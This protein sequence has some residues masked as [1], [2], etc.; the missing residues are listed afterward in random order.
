MQTLPGAHQ[1]YKLAPSTLCVLRASG[2]SHPLPSVEKQ[3][4]A[5]EKRGGGGLGLGGG[6]EELPPSHC[7]LGGGG[8]GP[9]GV[10]CC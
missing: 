4:A 8:H 2:T 6:G 7:G 10:L 3:M 1:E 9:G 5:M